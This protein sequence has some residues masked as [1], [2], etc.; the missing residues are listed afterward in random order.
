MSHFFYFT[1]SKFAKKRRIYSFLKCALF[2][3]IMSCSSVEVHRCFR[4]KYC[5]HIQSRNQAASTVL[6]S[7][8]LLNCLLSKKPKEAWTEAENRHIQGGTVFCPEL[9]SR[10]IDKGGCNMLYWLYAGSVISIQLALSPSSTIPHSLVDLPRYSR[11]A[12]HYLAQW[13]HRNAPLC[14]TNSR[15]LV[16]FRGCTVRSG[17][18]VCGVCECNNEVLLLW[19]LLKK[20]II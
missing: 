16:R 10:Q 3:V 14:R 7:A 2:S 8:C 12:S 6:L 11:S 19:V 18:F 5:F 17:T 20:I 13:R 15:S 9:Y 1:R 4:G